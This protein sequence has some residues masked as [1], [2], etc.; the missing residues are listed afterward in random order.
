MTDTFRTHFRNHEPV[1]LGQSLETLKT[2]HGLRFELSY[3]DACLQHILR[4]LISN[5]SNTYRP[6]QVSLLEQE[7]AELKAR[8]ANTVFQ[9]NQIDIQL[10]TDFYHLHRWITT[11]KELDPHSHYINLFSL[12]RKARNLLTVIRWRKQYIH[13]EDRLNAFQLT[14]YP[15]YNLLSSQREMQLNTDKLRDSIRFTLLEWEIIHTIIQVEPLQQKHDIDETMDVLIDC[16]CEMEWLLEEADSNELTSCA[17][18]F[19]HTFK[20]LKTQM[21]SEKNSCRD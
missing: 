5:A 7:I 10:C 15:L 12:L 3:L 1:S 16:L 11:A 17:K 20:V 13:L 2:I 19:H 6:G 21:A 14:Y 8:I 18:V 9:G 4:E